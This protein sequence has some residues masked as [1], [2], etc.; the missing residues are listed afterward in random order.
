[1]LQRVIHVGCIHSLRNLPIF[2]LRFNFTIC[3][4]ASGFEE[5]ITVLL[6]KSAVE[7]DF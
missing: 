1:M 2:P 3:R 6:T 4:D 7:S 5:P